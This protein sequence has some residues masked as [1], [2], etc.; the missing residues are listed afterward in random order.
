MEKQLDLLK[1]QAPPGGG[2]GTGGAPA[3]RVAELQKRAALLA[4]TTDGM[5]K[6]LE[7]TSRSHCYRTEAQKGL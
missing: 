3:E 6:A 7:G 2:G 1:A 4:N 5:L